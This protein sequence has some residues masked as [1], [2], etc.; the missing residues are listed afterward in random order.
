MK[1]TLFFT[2]LMLSLPPAAA[3]QTEGYPLSPQIITNGNPVHSGESG[4]AYDKDH[5]QYWT[6]TLILPNNTRIQTVST[7]FQ[8][9]NDSQVFFGSV[10]S[11]LTWDY[12]AHTLI[13]LQTNMPLRIVRLN[14]STA[15]ALGIGQRIDVNLP[16]NRVAAIAYAG[17]QELFAISAMGDE[18]LVDISAAFADG[19]FLDHTLPGPGMMIGSTG[20]Q[21]F[22]AMAFDGEFLWVM[23]SALMQI[24]KSYFKRS[25]Y[26]LPTLT[27]YDSP[28]YFP[29]FSSLYG[30]TV[31][32]PHLVL[33]GSENMLNK[34]GYQKINRNPNPSRPVNTMAPNISGQVNL[35]WP[36]CTEED[37]SGTYHIL[38][39]NDDSSVFRKETSPM[40]NTVITGLSNFE[41]YY[42]RVMPQDVYGAAQTNRLQIFNLPYSTGVPTRPINTHIVNKSSGPYYDIISA[43]MAASPGDRITITDNAAYT[44]PMPY[45]IVIPHLTIEAQAGAEPVLIST[46]GLV[47]M[48][49]TRDIKIRNL[50]LRAGKGT[51]GY[52]A[53]VIAVFSNQNL[54]EGCSI[55]AEESANINTGVYVSEMVKDHEIQNCV[56]G[57][58]LYYGIYLTNTYCGSIHDNRIYQ[59]Q[60]GIYD[61][62]NSIFSNII[63]R[64]RIQEIGKTGIRI[65]SRSPAL[66]YNT[67]YSCSNK[68]VCLTNMYWTTVVYHNTIAK[69]P[70]GLFFHT[71]NPNNITY[72]KNNIFYFNTKDC[73]M[74]GGW[75]TPNVRFEDNCCQTW[76]TNNFGAGSVFQEYDNVTDNPLFTDWANNDFTLTAESPCI[77]SGQGLNFEPYGLSFPYIG[78]GRDMGSHEYTFPSPPPSTNYTVLTSEFI[79]LSANNLTKGK[80]TAISFYHLNTIAEKT[81][82][83]RAVVYNLRGKIIKNLFDGNVPVDSRLKIAWDGRDG[84]NRYVSAGVYI[85]KVH[86]NSIVRTEKIFF[87]P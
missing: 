25:P 65:N 59:C 86:L 3:A 35:D 11:C 6:S 58:K 61:T 24:D 7:S 70:T 52:M 32:G 30:I 12:D 74:D 84:Q 44:N 71:M 66:F 49:M 17:N 80:E 9:N 75:S 19:N 31:Q 18:Y 22:S 29:G 26:G 39:G 47:F 63:Y 37:F 73:F 10:F 81:V 77:D 28:T 5:N 83:I 55:H 42:F 62:G 72:I 54:V 64:N 27:S 68:G 82:S 78:S 40:A 45:Y 34:V 50:N 85:L 60:Y 43:L 23:K 14:G 46:N 79:H 51:S 13:A 57:E 1:K 20:G 53:P 2:L 38:I 21:P 16:P 67:V 56:I 87:V 33:Y 15:Q 41:T 36:I 69:S 48:L 8:T 4:I 76:E